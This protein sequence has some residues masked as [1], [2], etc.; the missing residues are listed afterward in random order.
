MTKHTTDNI[1]QHITNDCCQCKQ[2]SLILVTITKQ[3]NSAS[4]WWAN[5]L[6]ATS[7]D[8]FPMTAARV[9]NSASFWQLSLSKA[10]QPLSDDQTYYITTGNIIQHISNDYCQLKQFSLILV[11][12]TKQSNSASFWWPNILQK[13]SFNTFPMTGVVTFTK[14]NNSGSFW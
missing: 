13:T 3:S 2:F 14:Q 8:I 4:Y 7:F 9:S 1:I 10:I 11:T 6:Q 5:I 12:I